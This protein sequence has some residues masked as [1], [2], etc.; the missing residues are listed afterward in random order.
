[1]NLQKLKT[2]PVKN[3]KGTKDDSRSL[4]VAVRT[5]EEWSLPA[6]ILVA[7][8]LSIL[9]VLCG[10]RISVLSRMTVYP[11]MFIYFSLPYSLS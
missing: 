3:K 9:P 8:I 6:G 4:G 1:M 2:L 10:N 11:V 7:Y 5:V